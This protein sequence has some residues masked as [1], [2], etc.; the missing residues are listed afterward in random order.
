MKH[1]NRKTSKVSLAPLIDNYQWTEESANN[2]NNSIDS[3]LIKSDIDVILNKSYNADETDVISG[4]VTAIYQK[5]ATLSLKKKK[6]FQPG[7]SSHKFTREQNLQYST[8]K[9]QLNDLAILFQKYPRD[10][11]I[12][13]QFFHLKKNFNRILKRIRKVQRDNILHKLH[14]LEEKNPPAFFLVEKKKTHQSRQE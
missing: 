8:L 4:Q 7:K 11:F 9:K 13:G 6:K 3:N 14:A 12:R 1:D 10:P 2:Y 5:A